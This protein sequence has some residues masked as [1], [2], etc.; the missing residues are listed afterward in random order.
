[1]LF[2]ATVFTTLVAGAS[3]AAALTPVAP[4]GQGILPELVAYLRT[5]SRFNGEAALAGLPYAVAILGIL[6]SHELG[7]WLMARAWKVDATLP[8]FVPGFEPIGT[9]GAVI[10]M[11][12]AIPSRRAILDI[13][14]AGPIGGL[15]VALPLLL[16]GTAHSEVR[17]LGDAWLP[18]GQGS[19]L[20]HVV[21]AIL[22]GAKGPRLV[23]VHFGDSLLTWAVQRLVLGP[24]PP[25]AEVLAHPVFMAAW[26]GLFI[27]T[28][29][30][31]PIGQLD[32]GHVLYA[33]LGRRGAL[34]ASRTVSWG[35]FAAGVLLSWNW[36]L[37]WAIT[38]FLVRLGHPPALDDAPLDR[39]RVAVALLSLLLFAVTF[40]PVPV[41][42]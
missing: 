18:S 41:T 20:W 25:H 36:L 40:V 28:L 1:V 27:T 22:E 21:A 34:L 13:G 35:L 6:L 30:L 19:G 4:S 38:R 42:L 7:H 2:A 16:W 15:L 33:L 39:P 31:L 8:F 24:L 11:R 32:G 5:V 29:N 17:V 9:F 3:M 37:W 23:N 12:S 26:F 10:R 14:A